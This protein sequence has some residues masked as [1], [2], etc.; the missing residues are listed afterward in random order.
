MTEPRPTDLQ[1]AAAL[2]AH[3]PPTAPAGLREGIQQATV[4][5]P[6]QRAWP[7]LLGALTDADPIARRRTTALV[8]VALLLAALAGAAAIGALKLLQTPPVLPAGAVGRFAY[9]SDGDLYVASPDGSGH[10][11]VAHVDGAELSA[12]R[13]SGDGRWIAVQTPEPGILLVDMRNGDIRRLAGGSIGGWSPDSRSLAYFTANGDIAVVDVATGSSRTLVARPGG[14]DGMASGWGDPL[15][16]SPDGRWLID[17]MPGDLNGRPLALL[18]IDPATGATKILDQGRESYHYVADWAPDSSR[19]VFTVEGDRQ[20][21]DT[22][23]IT[24]V[25]GSRTTEIREPEAAVNTPRW[26]PDGKWI[27]YLLRRGEG[28]QLAIARPDGSDRRTLAD[29]I[30]GIVGW[31]GD[32]VSI[33]YAVARQVESGPDRFVVHVVTLADG[34]DRAL[35]VPELARD[36]QWATALEGGADPKT[37]PPA[38]RPTPESPIRVAASGEPLWPDASWGGL[39]FRTAP[40]GDYDCFVGVVRFPNEP[41]VVKPGSSGAS[42]GGSAGNGPTPGPRKAEYCEF[43]FAPDGSSFVRSDQND[44][45]YEVVRFDGTTL[46]G[47]R[48]YEGGGPPLWSPGGGWLERVACEAS[49]DCGHHAIERPDGSGHRDVPG[50]PEW[51]R[52]DRVLAVAAS[53]GTLLVGDG[54]GSNLHAIGDF[55]LP[56]GWSPDGSTFVFVRDGDAWLASADGGNVRNLTSFPLGGATASSWSR[57]GRWIAVLQ[58][59]TVWMVAPDGSSRHRVG[60]DMPA[61]VDDYT[62]AG[63]PV[64]SPAWSPT[65]SW[66][67]IESPSQVVLVNTDDWRTVRIDGAVQP[68]WSQD[69]RHLAVVAGQYVVNVMNP[70]GSNRTVIGTSIAYPPVVWLPR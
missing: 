8:A 24:D 58:G 65:D 52:D 67:A 11:L 57:D 17:D 70:D 39:A 10:A 4:A 31:S 30:N 66:A 13:W 27:A 42:T 9:V 60:T 59:T 51:S 18:R 36:V 33:A 54:D 1:L 21:S 44:D 16:F 41:S 15:A 23:W 25:S 28:R 19:V 6:Q 62:T 20:Y 46:G 2:R 3:L 34:S 32:G 7:T 48:S 26:S 64:W 49:G 14:S 63:P 56:G 12:P 35:S 45:T 37:S 43:A 22:L 69:G 68:A 50:K 40:D 29:G 47:P 61:L 38:A 5:A 53:D 55:P